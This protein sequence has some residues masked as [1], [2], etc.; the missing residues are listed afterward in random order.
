LSH[1]S[2]IVGWKSG[3]KLT[4][5]SFKHNDMSELRNSLHKLNRGSHADAPEKLIVVE[6]IYSMDGDVCPIKELFDIAEEFDA[7]V[8]V[9]EAHSTGVVGDRGEGLVSSFGLQ[10][11][12]NL[13]GSYRYFQT[14][15][16][17]VT[18]PS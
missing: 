5:E 7:M 13:L 2:L 12:Q 8:V 15:F 14:I 10:S 3:R 1:N 17:T 11:H 4:H 9:D 18:T 6:S 16:F